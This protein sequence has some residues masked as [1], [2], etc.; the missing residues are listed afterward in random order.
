MKTRRG[1][2]GI[3]AITRTRIKPTVWIREE[4]EEEEEEEKEEEEEEEECEQ[5]SRAIDLL[6][7]KK[8]ELKKRL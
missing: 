6:E 5:G 3:K 1:T 7:K 4:E 2:E 8:R